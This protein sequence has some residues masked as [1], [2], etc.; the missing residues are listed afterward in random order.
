[1][2][3]IFSLTLITALAALVDLSAAR[4]NWF[5]HCGSN[6]LQGATLLSSCD[7]GGASINLNDY[8]ANDFGHLDWRNGGQFGPSC[9]S[10]WLDYDI[11]R[12]NCGRGDGSLSTTD[13]DLEEH[14]CYSGNSIYYC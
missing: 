4:G 14:L 5:E 8:I 6:S 2:Q 13:I 10:C 11:L 9:P 1:M 3:H 7:G 12:C